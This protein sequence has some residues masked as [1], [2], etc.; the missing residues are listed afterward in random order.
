MV[1]LADTWT[2]GSRRESDGWAVSGVSVVLSSRDEASAS[3]ALAY[4][5]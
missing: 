1:S 4:V 5:M 2:P 3:L